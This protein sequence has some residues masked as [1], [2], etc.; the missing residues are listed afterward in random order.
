PDLEQEWEWTER[1]ATQPEILRYVDHVASRFDLRRD[2]EFSTRVT[3]AA[4]DDGSNRWLVE[5]DRGHRVRAQFLIMAVGCLSAAKLPE[6]AG[7]ERFDGDTYHT[8]RWP[9]G[10]VDFTGKRVGVK[11]L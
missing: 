6:V 9:H 3:A 1:Y 11:P 10:G 5:T 8:G 2:V 4:W 7:L